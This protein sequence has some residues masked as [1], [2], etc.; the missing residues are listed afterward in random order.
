[1]LIKLITILACGL[2]AVA[3]YIMMALLTVMAREN[4]LPDLED[5]EV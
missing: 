3:L 4:E 2:S 1:M 5:I